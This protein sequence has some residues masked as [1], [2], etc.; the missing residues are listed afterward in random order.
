MA[1]SRRHT[2]PY[3]VG[4]D[5]WVIPSTS[6]TLSQVL[7]LD[8]LSEVQLSVHFGNVLSILTRLYA[9]GKVLHVVFLSYGVEVS[10]VTSSFCRL[11]PMD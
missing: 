4:S 3:T 1:P 7:C 6:S 2:R 8:D 10:I 5:V 11:P 9:I